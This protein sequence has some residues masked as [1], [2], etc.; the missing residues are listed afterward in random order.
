MLLEPKTIVI[1][2][3][4]VIL[5]KFTS[6]DALRIIPQY[7]LSRGKMYSTL[8]KL[9][10]KNKD[11][12]LDNI[13]TDFTPLTNEKLLIEILSHCG[14]PR[15]NLQPLQLN[16]KQI[17]CSHFTEWTDLLILE[18]NIIGYNFQ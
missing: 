7:A 18:I 15:E 2:D 4:E 9:F 16:N 11:L 17:I 8:V 10:M 12:N 3:K 5:S 1:G 6:M 13:G 14:I